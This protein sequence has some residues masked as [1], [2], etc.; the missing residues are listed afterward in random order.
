MNQNIL[1]MVQITKEFP[2][3]KALNNVNLSVKQGEIHALVGENGAGKSTLMNVL[4]GIYPHGTY[5]GKILFNG[6]EC[7]FK[8]I[9]DSERKGI[10][11]INQELAL[12]PYLSI[13][14]NMFIGNE[15][16]K[17][18]IIDWNKTHGQ[19]TELL[20]K[21]GLKE[22]SDI[23]I[24]D[25]SVGKQ[26][27]VEIA[28]ALAKEVKLLILD[29]PTAALNEEE[30]NN[31]L[32]LLLELKAEGM[33]SILISH[34]LSEVSKVA[35]SITIVRDG[36][37]IE[38]L[39]KGVDDIGEDRI[40]KGMV[41]REI[42]DRFPKRVS[43]IGDMAF[44]IYNWNIFDPIVTEHQIIKNASMNVRKGEVVG[45][46]GL[47]GAGRTELAMSVFGKAYGK[48]I[49]GK[50]KKNGQEITI[51]TVKD[52]IDNHIAYVTEDRKTSGLILIDDIKWN[53]SLSSLDRLSK[54]QVI[55][56]NRE[57]Q[58][59]EEYRKKLNIK[60]SSILQKVGNL[61]GGNQQKVVL[62]K[63]IMAQPDVLILDEP[64]RG[65]DVGAKYEI[66]T[67]INQL[68]AEGKSIIIISSELPEV[69][70]MSDRI[71]VMNAGRIVGELDKDC[72]SQENIMKCIMNSNK[73]AI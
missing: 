52:A 37:T 39:V 45:L 66:Y 5:T 60:S 49:S 7:K 8:T 23:H 15:R 17:K 61:S 11:I 50:L 63:W 46:Y 72:A 18:S 22:K 53:S 69:L 38:T 73:E 20:K 64:T 12:V 16:A 41:G 33:T 30:S 48:N 34:K 55:D 6:I 68:V 70:G 58:A 62:S 56:D 4:S 40:I 51:N 26:Q 24:K 59:A 21:V 54:H 67:I 65:I 9:K 2:G 28:K 36:A 31:L 42:V 25:I 44:E 29:E 43:K 35:D 10:V 19:C 27:L 71:Y 32:N 14:E 3:V 47:M 1:E 57:I 13:A